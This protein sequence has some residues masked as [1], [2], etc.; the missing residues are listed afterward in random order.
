MHTG[1]VEGGAAERDR[2]P[3]PDAHAD[4]D[5]RARTHLANE[6][7]FL[8]WLRTGLG[9]IVLGLAAAQ[10]MEVD[11]TLIAGIRAVSDFAAVLIV[12]GAVIVLIGS[13]RYFRARD[14]IEAARFQPAGRGIT[15]ATGLVMAVAALSLAAVYL[16][17]R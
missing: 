13:A 6:R 14:Q 15:L 5:S 9:L 17:G 11:R 10:F 3:R 12:A 1:H 7:T 16:L 8:A 4:S 2:A